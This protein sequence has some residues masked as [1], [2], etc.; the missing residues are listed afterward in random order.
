MTDTSSSE[1]STSNTET[2]EGDIYVP[3]ADNS[4][5]LLGQAELNDLVCDLGITQGKS[6]CLVPDFQI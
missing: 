2:G 4:P 6:S 5:H 3:D 1:E